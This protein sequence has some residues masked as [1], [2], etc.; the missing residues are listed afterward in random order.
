MRIT[1]ACIGKLREK[2]SKDAIKSYSKCISKYCAFE[3][4]EVNDIAAPESLSGAEEAELKRCESAALYSK[5]HSGSY[6]IALDLA[7][8]SLGSDEFV[9]KIKAI[10]EN[11]RSDITF[12]IGG[13]L[14]LHEDALRKSDFRLS[15]S[16]MTFPHQL[17]RLILA[18][19]M[20]EVL[21]T[22]SRKM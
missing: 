22:L 15:L 14:G 7:G 16:K 6:I 8:E 1:I 18:E 19:Q 4:I 11:G 9:Q 10:E 3:I 12:T 17:A 13:S 2:Y 20:C 5:I 21:K